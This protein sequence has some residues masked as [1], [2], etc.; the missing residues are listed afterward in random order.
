[1]GK[2]WLQTTDGRLIHLPIVGEDKNTPDD[3]VK[4]P[5]SIIGGVN[6]CYSQQIQVVHPSKGTIVFDFKQGSPLIGSCNQC[7]QCCTHPVNA[8]KSPAGE[9]GWPYRANINAHACQYL[10]VIR[11]NKWGQAGNS[12]CSIYADILNRFKGCAFPP[13]E[14]KPHMTSCG[15]HL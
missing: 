14:L 13:E 3:P 6:R 7:G 2:I 4:I 11:L 9:C 1:M 12:E 5:V 8:C 10:K 15:Y